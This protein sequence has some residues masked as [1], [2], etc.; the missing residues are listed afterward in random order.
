MRTG[1]FPT[2]RVAAG[3]GGVGGGRR[4]TA[5]LLPV[6][7]IAGGALV[8]AFW[9]AVPGE[10]TWLGLSVVGVLVLSGRMLGGRGARGA[11]RSRGVS[12]TASAAAPARPTPG[13]DLGRLIQTFE[14]LGIAILLT[15]AGGTVLRANATA[16]ELLQRE[17]QMP[18]AALDLSGTFFG[19]P[20]EEAKELA[21][22][23]RFFGSEDESGW[24]KRWRVSASA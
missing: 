11:R 15:D 2:G 7:A 23:H 13:D 18:R 3:R 9:G 24:R 20:V 8:G 4:G 19:L 1:T 16:S 17:G 6:L 14:D 5:L 22:L 10:W 12:A 21:S